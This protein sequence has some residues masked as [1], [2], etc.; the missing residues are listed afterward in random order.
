MLNSLPRLNLSYVIPITFVALLFIMMLTPLPDLGY[1]FGSLVNFMHIPVFAGLSLIVWVLTGPLLVHRP[2]AKAFLVWVI[3]GLIGSGF[4]LLQ[5]QSGRS[6]SLHDIGANL[7]GSGLMLSFLLSTVAFTPKAQR[8]WRIVSLGCL[9][10][11]FYTPLTE[12]Y[13]VCR[14]RL[15]FPRIADFETSNELHRWR[16]ENVTISRSEHFAVDSRYSLHVEFHPGRFSAIYIPYSVPDWRE[17]SQLVMDIYVPAESAPVPLYLKLE[18]SLH[19]GTYDDRFHA[20]YDL[21]PG[22]HH[23]TI[24]LSDIKLAAREF[25]L[26]TV[27]LFQFMLW[28]QDQPHEFYVDAI[29]LE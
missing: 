11:A 12:V 28:E 4:E 6:A 15:E 25:D 22:S 7:V 27:R 1:V 13:D 23:L 5:Y 29:R 17:Y 8:F 19:D 20:Y 14:M 9:F 3:V 24:P 10:V 21:E 2:V 16:A 26:S 18:D